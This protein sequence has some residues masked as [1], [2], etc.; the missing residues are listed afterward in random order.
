MQIKTE[1][2]DEYACKIHSYNQKVI[3][4]VLIVLLIFVFVFSFFLK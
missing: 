3:I 2:I 4:Y 1:F